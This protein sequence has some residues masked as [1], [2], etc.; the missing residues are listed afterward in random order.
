MLI[1]VC[2]EDTSASRA[3]F[4][5]L[6]QNYVLKEYRVIEV[7]S[8][9]LEQIPAWLSDSYSLFETHHIFSTELINKKINKQ[10]KKLMETIETIAKDKQNTLI[11]WEQCSKRELKYGAASLIKEFKPKDTI[12]KL[13]DSIYPG[14][15]KS[16]IST[17]ETVSQNTDATFIFSMIS[18]HIRS[19]ILAKQE[20]F[21]EKLQ[22]WQIYKI[23]HNADRWDLEKLSRYY[24]G[25]GRIDLNIKTSGSP[26]DIKRSLDILACYFL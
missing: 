1:I 13:L 15:R 6:I 26:F 3:Y 22:Q 8:D 25:L 17:L 12:F 23:K 20:I 10:G 7:I 11:V 18:K 16:F 14:N 4:N 2:G 9:S 21:K 5:S 24:E 19:L